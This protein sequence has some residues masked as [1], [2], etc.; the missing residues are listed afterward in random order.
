LATWIDDEDAIILKK[1]HE[2]EKTNVYLAARVLEFYTVRHRINNTHRRTLCTIYTLEGFSGSRQPG[3][4]LGAMDTS[5]TLDTIASGGEQELDRDFGSD[6]ECADDDIIHE[7]AVT[8]GEIL[9]HI[10]LD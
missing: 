7:Q 10:S 2:L 6:E 1:A 3:V 5:S 9:E 8:L 4:R